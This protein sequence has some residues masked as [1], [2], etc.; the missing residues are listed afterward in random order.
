MLLS[1]AFSSKN[2][3]NLNTHKVALLFSDAGS[4]TEM[5]WILLGICISLG[6]LLE[7]TLVIIAST[8]AITAF[9][10]GRDDK[11]VICI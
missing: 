6:S 8:V 4:S 2:I 5:D 9:K 7:I 11:S 3:Q 10:K 1:W